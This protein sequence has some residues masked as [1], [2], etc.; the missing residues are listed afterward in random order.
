VK[1]DA[2]RE[3]ATDALLRTILR[4]NG[5]VVDGACLD[6]ETAAAWTD[7]A[8][9][10]E[11]RRAL[12]QHVAAC[13]RCQAV[14]ASIARSAPP[15]ER[16]PL[17]RRARM[18]WL[19]PATALAALS[20]FVWTAVDSEHARKSPQPAAARVPAPPSQPTQQTETVPVTEEGRRAANELQQKELEKDA[21]KK[22]RTEFRDARRQDSAAK[23]K[24]VP[25]S[26][27]RPAEPTAL[28]PANEAVRVITP[29]PLPPTAAPPAPVG[30]LPSSAAGQVAG[31]AKPEGA[32]SEKVLPQSPVFDRLAAADAVAAAADIVAPDQAYRWRIVNRTR[33]LRSIDSGASWQTQ[34]PPAGVELNAGSAPSSSVCWLVGR[35]GVVLLTVDGGQT[36]QRLTAPAAVDLVRIA[37]MSADA[38]T[39]TLADG[40]VFATTDRGKTWSVVRDM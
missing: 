30:P 33:L 7:D 32:A 5:D 39:V 6:A 24:T 13:A 27:T 14:L 8:L 20:V 25:E 40:R 21:L 36:W 35:T 11:E 37:A 10:R 16:V 2:R 17:W 22:D 1:P 23:A 18:Q 3:R 4:E 38:A 28:P 12:E 15:L 19:L 34:T 9:G 29:P 31:A 26:P